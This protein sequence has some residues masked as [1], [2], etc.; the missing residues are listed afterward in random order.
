ML[1]LGAECPV[2][3]IL[4]MMQVLDRCAA[5]CGASESVYWNLTPGP[6]MMQDDLV[7][8]DGLVNRLGSAHIIYIM[9]GLVLVCW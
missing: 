7:R 9:P 6:A 8:G 1:L 3:S 2:F 5:M 4:D